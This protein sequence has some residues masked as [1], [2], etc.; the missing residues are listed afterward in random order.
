[1]KLRHEPAPLLLLLLPCFHFSYAIR[2]PEEVAAL[3]QGKVVGPSP[4]LSASLAVQTNTASSLTAKDIA[5][6]GQDGDLVSQTKKVDAS[7]GL[8][9]TPLDGKDGRPH[10]GPFVET[11]AERERKKAKESGDE[12][13]V[14]ALKKPTSKEETKGSSSTDGKDVPETNDGVMDDPNRLGP[15]EGTRGTEGGISEKNRIGKGQ[16]GTAGLVKTE[17]KPDPPKEVPPLPHSEQEKLGKTDVKDAGKGNKENVIEDE[18]KFKEKH[19]GGLEV[20]MFARAEFD[21]H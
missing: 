17:K 19:I 14:A 8:K 15:K 12:E 10:Q 1:M 4:S 21:E 20:T 18:D 16:E 6:G 3:A 9:D 11:K 13:P 2:S 5:A 7:I